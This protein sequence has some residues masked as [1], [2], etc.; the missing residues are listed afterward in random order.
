[1]LESPDEEAR[2]IGKAWDVLVRRG[3]SSSAVYMKHKWGCTTEIYDSTTLDACLYTTPFG[4]S[5]RS[6]RWWRFDPARRD[7]LDGKK[8]MVNGDCPYQ[9]DLAK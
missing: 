1:L 8:D 9:Y 7:C 2:A 4:V 5:G 6:L 3:Q